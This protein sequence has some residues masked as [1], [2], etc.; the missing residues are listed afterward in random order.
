MSKEKTSKSS[1]TIGYNGNVTVKIIGKNGKINKQYKGKN[2]GKLPLFRY[3]AYAICGNFDSQSCPIFIATYDNAG[4]PTC[5]NPILKGQTSISTSGSG[6][7][8]VASASL[9]FTIP[10]S[11][12]ISGTQTSVV[13]LFDSE[14]YLTYNKNDMNP[15]A[16]YTLDESIEVS[17]DE[18][19]LVVWQLNISN[20]T[21]QGE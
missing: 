6:D 17:A 15:S 13:R 9:I 3:L 2:S 7:L 1:N 5:I 8:A 12:F 11:T 4:N 14:Y 20:N 21:A 18:N 10:G 16:E 19:L